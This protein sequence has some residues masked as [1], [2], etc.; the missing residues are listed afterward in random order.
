M[1]LQ[2]RKILY[3]LCLLA[4]SC[5][6]VDTQS[7]FLPDLEQKKWQ[8]LILFVFVL[9]LVAIPISSWFFGKFKYLQL[10]KKT[11]QEMV[12][13]RHLQKLQLATEQQ[14]EELL[15]MQ[16][17]LKEDNLS[18][19][20][21]RVNHVENNCK[22]LRYSKDWKADLCWD[23]FSQMCDKINAHFFLLANKLR[24]AGEL[25]E[26]EIRLCVLVLLDRFDSRQMAELLFYAES[27]IRNYKQKVA[28]KLGTTSKNLRQFLVD[29]AVS[30][31]I[32]STDL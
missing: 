21:L 29:L 26:K 2:P 4:T 12:R 8:L 11:K 20:R 16:Q 3:I 10:R 30:G 13:Q 17:K 32:N 6:A 9:Y 27:G 19:Y 28:Q 5:T 22:A 7:V 25:H 15:A 18:Y 14:N 31:T 24:S 23:D 1:K